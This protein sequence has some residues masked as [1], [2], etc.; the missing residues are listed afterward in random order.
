MVTDS[1]SYS[2]GVI[3]DGRNRMIREYTNCT[4]VYVNDGMQEL[5]A[6]KLAP[7]IHL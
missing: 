4:M 7:S 5:A 3:D 6:L 2:Y 1:Y